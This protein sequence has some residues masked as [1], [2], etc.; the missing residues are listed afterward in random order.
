MENASNALLIAGMVLVGI[1]I[2]TLMA[3]LFISAGKVTKEHTNEIEKNKI[4][5]FNSYFTK[6]LGVE[7]SVHQVKSIYNFARENDFAENDICSN[8]DL[9]NKI[10][11]DNFLSDEKNYNYKY[12]LT[13]EGYTDEGY[14]K[15]INLSVIR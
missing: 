12:K 3:T 4:N 14:I 6:Y 15:A 13:I 7:L 10:C 5:E 1:L 8:N 11:S 2:L 9:L